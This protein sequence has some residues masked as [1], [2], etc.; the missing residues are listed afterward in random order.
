MRIR[1]ITLK[2]VRKFGSEATAIQ[3][4]K[5][6][7][8][9]IIL[10]NNGCGKTTILD[11]IAVMLSP[12][13]VRFINKGMRQFT[14]ADI[15]VLDNEQVADYLE[16]KLNL[17]D[18]NNPQV[19]EATRTLKGSGIDIP[20]SNLS[21][22]TNS[23]DHLKRNIQNGLDDWLPILAYYG[24]GRGKIDVIERKRNFQQAFARW[25]CYG[26][27]ALEA[28]SDFKTFLAWFD[29]MEDEERRIKLETRDLQYQHPLLE[30]VRKALSSVFSLMDIGNVIN[31]R[32]ELHP[33]RFVVDEILADGSTKEMRLDNQLSDGYRI[34]I[35]MTADIAYRMATA[36]PNMGDS[37]LLTP[38]VVL[39]DEIDL[40]LHPKWQYKV[41]CALH[42]TFP[43]IQFIVTTHSPVIV[44]GA[45]EIAQVIHLQEDGQVTPFDIKSIQHD[46]VN[47]LLL[48]QLFGLP[49]VYAPQYQRIKEEREEL[50]CKD[51]LSLAE[52]QRLA[53]LDN[54]MHN[55]DS[56]LGTDMRHL[57]DLLSK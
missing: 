32:I 55:Y 17:Y 22:L 36:N 48:G 31:P 3:F 11:S 37:I 15:H 10:A 4:D 52:Q 14:Q 24:T 1:D 21:F 56:S 8:V 18:I 33:I 49:N 34:L 42:K 6:K 53:D 47:L 23:A 26:G 27:G 40:H 16:C 5:E 43:N 29:L 44:I 41:L 20:S 7:H 51:Q 39:V 54:Q 13:I 35:A 57:I 12:Y 45:Q 38:G 2:N 30:A 50:I 28:A 19:V 9:S 46:N 25:D